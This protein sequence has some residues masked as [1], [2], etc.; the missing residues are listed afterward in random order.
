ML[1]CLW[2]EKYN[3]APPMEFRKL[4]D[5]CNYI[6]SDLKQKIDTL[7]VRKKSGDELDIENRIEVLNNFLE[8]Q[9]EK[10]ENK[11][12]EYD[13]HIITTELLDEVFRKYIN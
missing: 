7:F 3:I 11:A 12:T 4:Y 13:F 9:I 10:I 8:K 5:D 6:S 1:A 2:V